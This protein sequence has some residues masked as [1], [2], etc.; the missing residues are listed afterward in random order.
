ASMVLGAVAGPVWSAADPAPQPAMTPSPQAPATTPP[1]S[2]PQPSAP[3]ESPLPSQ[4]GEPARS[5]APGSSPAPATP[6][7]QTPGDGGAEGAGCGFMDMS[8]LAKQAV[9]G[10]FADLVTSAAEPVCDL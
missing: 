6:G 4:P 9:N 3:V 7:E 1:P 10:W 5:P 2:S 8:C